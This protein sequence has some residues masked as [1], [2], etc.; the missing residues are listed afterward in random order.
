MPTVHF[1]QKVFCGHE[2]TLSN[3][4][5][6]HSVEPLNDH[7][8]AKLSWAQ[9][10]H[11]LPPVGLCRGGRCSVEFGCRDPEENAQ[12]QHDWPWWPLLD[13]CG[14]GAFEATAKQPG[15]VRKSPV[16]TRAYGCYRKGMRT[17]CPLCHPPWARSCCTTLS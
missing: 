1:P 14:L 4:E 10:G 15:T 2:H 5:F 17:M 7:V 13:W 12:G 16:V 6:A 9:V 8:K 3:L 11:F